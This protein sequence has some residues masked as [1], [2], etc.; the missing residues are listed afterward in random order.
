[1]ILVLT[2]YSQGDNIKVKMLGNASDYYNEDGLSHSMMHPLM[3][4]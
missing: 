1:M 2:G 4:E 3:V